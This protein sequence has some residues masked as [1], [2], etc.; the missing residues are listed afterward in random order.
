MDQNRIWLL[1]H[2]LLRSSK[3][4]PHFWF[5]YFSKLSLLVQDTELDFNKSLFPM[6][7]MQ[8]NRIWSRCN[9][10]SLVM[11]KRSKYK[12]KDI[13]HNQRKKAKIKGFL[14]APHLYYLAR[15]HWCWCTLNI[16][17]KLPKTGNRYWIWLWSLHAKSVRN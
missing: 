8:S 4:N 5:L 14:T 3:G 6:A 9:R 7:L 2:K 13:C 1:I 11:K 12:T 15:T 16:T 17:F 10:V